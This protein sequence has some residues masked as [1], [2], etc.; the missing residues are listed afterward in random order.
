MLYVYI[1]NYKSE[2]T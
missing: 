1:D 2:T